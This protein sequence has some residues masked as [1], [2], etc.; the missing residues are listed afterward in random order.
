VEIPRA[1]ATVGLVVDRAHY[2]L[3]QRALDAARVSVWIGTANVKE[4]MVEAP[5]G[6]RARARDRYISGAPTSPGQGSAP[7]ARGAATSSSAS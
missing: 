4:M 3:V 7:R 5:V 1:L 6:T 2:E